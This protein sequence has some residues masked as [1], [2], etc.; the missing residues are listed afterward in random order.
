MMRNCVSL[1]EYS[2]NGG[3][4]PIS[5]ICVLHRGS[6]SSWLAV[7]YTVFTTKE[8]P[9]ADIGFKEKVKESNKGFGGGIREIISLHNEYA[10]EN[11]ALSLVQFFTW[12]G[13]FLMWFYYNTAVARNVFHAASEKEVNIDK[14]CR[15]CR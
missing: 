11:E 4:S 15:I 14:R 8:Y 9:P 13:L 7:L 2:E 10:C 12:P 5:K 3:Y 1:P 6:F